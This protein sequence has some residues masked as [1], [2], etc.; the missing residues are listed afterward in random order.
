FVRGRS[1]TTC[2][3]HHCDR[4]VV[5]AVDIK[6]FFPSITRDMVEK[7]T[8]DMVPE[9]AKNKELFDLVLGAITSNDAL[10][11]GS[12]AS[13]TLS[14]LVFNGI[15]N[16]LVSLACAFKA[17]YSRYADDLF[18]SSRYNRNLPGIISSV[19]RILNAHGFSI[20]RKKVRVMRRGQRQVVAGLI[21]NGKTPAVGREQL[22]SLRAAIHLL[23]KE[24][25]GAGPQS[26]SVAK[27]MESIQGKISFFHMVNPQ[28]VRRLARTFKAICRQQAARSS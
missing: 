16:Q 10:P 7:I 9:L 6:D 15:D 2:A 25:Q 23:E 13:P 24:L 17:R 3:R 4:L 22:R 11:Q 5:V 28:S 14:N 18:F 19:E 20:N 12:P 1:I 8:R 26:P 27:L 21:V